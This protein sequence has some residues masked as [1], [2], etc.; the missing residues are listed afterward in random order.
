MSSGD[1]TLVSN[2]KEIICNKMLKEICKPLQ[3]I[4]EVLEDIVKYI[5]SFATG[6][7]MLKRVFRFLAQVLEC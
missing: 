2:W 1:T 3:Y 7:K 5:E 6:L 4:S